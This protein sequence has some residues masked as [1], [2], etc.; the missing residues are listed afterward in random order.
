MPDKNVF[1]CRCPC[2]YAEKPKQDPRKY[3]LFRKDGQ[4]GYVFHDFLE[5]SSPAYAAR[6][7]FP[8]FLFIEIDKHHPQYSDIDPIS[9]DRSEFSTPFNNLSD[10]LR[11]Q[12]FC[13]EIREEPE[14]PELFFYSEPGKYDHE[15]M[16]NM[17]ST[18][19]FENILKYS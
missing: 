18:M 7:S 16:K 1:I 10:I 11:Q 19:D 14:K 5:T 13:C 2:S 3:M 4:D 15:F 12:N 6:R 9:P 8:D 17:I